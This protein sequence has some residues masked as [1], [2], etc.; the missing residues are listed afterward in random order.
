VSALK[1][2]NQAPTPLCSSCKNPP[3][4]PTRARI[5]SSD[6]MKGGRVL[7]KQYGMPGH[8]RVCRSTACEPPHQMRARTLSLAPHAFASRSSAMQYPRLASDVSGAS[9]GSCHARFDHRYPDCL[10]RSVLLRRHRRE[11]SSSKKNA[12]HFEKVLMSEPL[13]KPSTGPSTQGRCMKIDSH[14]CAFFALV[15]P[16]QRTQQFQKKYVSF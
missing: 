13:S 3:H 15:S 5:V 9:W 7:P 4:I 1:N 12:S 14:S 11:L 2:H 10:R 6:T 8:P 16:S